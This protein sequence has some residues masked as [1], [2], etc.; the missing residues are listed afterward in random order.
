MQWFPVCTCWK[1]STD[2]IGCEKD[3]ERAKENSLVASELVAVRAMVCLGK[4]L[5]KDG[6]QGFVWFGSGASKEDASCGLTELSGQIR[7]FSSG[8]GDASVVFAIGRA[9][10][11][12][13]NNEKRTV[14]GSDCTFDNKGKN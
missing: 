7:Y 3:V 1:I 13:I 12:H 11:R 9:L 14:F 10:K 6:P 8:I 2:A 4:L 5:D